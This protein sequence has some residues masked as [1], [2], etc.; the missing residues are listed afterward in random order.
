MALAQITVFRPLDHTEANDILDAVHRSLVESL[1]V[2]DDD[3]RVWVTEQPTQLVHPAS[4][5][6][7]HIFIQV[8]L[9]S[10]RSLQTKQQLHNEIGKRLEAAGIP[11]SDVGVVMLESPRENWSVAGVPSDQVDLGFRVEI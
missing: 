9:F 3:P 7:P 4:R 5:N 11:P 2:P 8:T 10:G 6:R 1:Q